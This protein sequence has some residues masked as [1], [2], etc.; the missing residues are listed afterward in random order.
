[1]E[2]ELLVASILLVAVVVAA[3]PA[4]VLGPVSSI[5]DVSVGEYVGDTDGNL[6][7][8]VGGGESTCRFSPDTTGRS[9]KSDDGGFW[10]AGVSATMLLT[11]AGVLP[12]TWG[13]TV[14]E[15]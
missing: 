2:T 11:G 1:M 6:D 9:A 3:T 5:S 15:G 13:A 8:R 12:L 10:G 14:G 7:S 4:V